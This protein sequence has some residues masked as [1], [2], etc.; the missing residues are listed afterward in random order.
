MR[1]IAGEHRGRTIAAPPGLTTRPTPDRVRGALFSALESR[2]GGPGSLEGVRV[3]DLFAGSGALGIEA[4]S[5]GAAHATFVERNPAALTI[6][7][8]NLARL[9]L[10]DASRVLAKDAVDAVSEL[11]GGSERYDAAFLDPPY[12]A[13]ESE[14]ALAALGRHRLVRPGGV[15]VLEHAS[16]DE[17]PADPA[18]RRDRTRAYGTVSLTIYVPATEPGSSEG[19]P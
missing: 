3:L 6:L 12:G 14:A 10:L 4:L 2:L 5:R 7:K 18:W 15:L 16:G 1:I 11:A 17:P 13:P 9:G 19:A 8:D